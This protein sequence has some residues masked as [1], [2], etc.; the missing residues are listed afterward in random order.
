MSATRQPKSTVKTFT[1][2]YEEFMPRVFRFM[3]YRVN[4]VHTSEDLTSAVFEKA[5]VNF[6]RYSSDRASFSTWIFTIARNTVIDY[7][8]AR[9]RRPTASLEEAEIEVAS[10]D[11]PPGDALERREQADRLRE[12]LLKLPVEEQELISM[13]FGGGL[14]NRQIARSLGLS[15]SN[16]GTRLYRTVRKLRDGFREAES[17]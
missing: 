16:V 1:E 14:N 8:R 9:G 15:E 7:Y 6:E 17:G 2:L 3:R 11:P 4:D 12:Q 10:S 5:L 13:K